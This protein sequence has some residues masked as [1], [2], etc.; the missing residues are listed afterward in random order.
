MLNTIY[1]K[2]LILFAF[3][4]AGSATWAQSP[5]QFTINMTGPST[6]TFLIEVIT[7][8]LTAQNNVFQFASTAPGTYQVMNIGRFVSN[9]KAFDK[10][11]KTI[12]V[13]QTNVNQFEI[14]QPE[15]VKK[16]T[17]SVAETFDTK[18]TEFPVYRMGGSSLE[19]DH[20]LLNAHTMLGY[21]VGMQDADIEIGLIHPTDW[22]VGTPLSKNK[23][24]FYTASSFDFAVDSPILL[25]RL[26]EASMDVEGKKIEIYT[27]SVTDMIKSTDLMTAMK[28]IFLAANTFVKG[29][30]VDRYVLLFHFED[31]SWGAWEHSYSSEYVLKE[32]P[33]TPET[34]QG[35]ASIAA[36]EIFHMVTP[37]NIHSEII[38]KFNFV[39]PT[40]SVHLWLYEGVTEWASDLMQLRAGLV[41]LEGTLEQIQQKLLTDDQF[42][43][44]YS[45]VKLAETSFEP[46]GNKQYGNIYNRG[47]LVPTL[48]DILLLEKSGGTR[49]L[50]EVVIELSKKYGPSK[51]F[52]E[53]DFF[54]EFVAITYPE[55]GPFLDNYIK[56]TEPLP[57]A[58]YF[59]KLGIEYLPET[60]NGEME[61]DRGHSINYNGKNLF[62]PE[63][64]ELSQS[65][66]L[67]SGDIILSIN[68]IEAAP[69]NFG[70]LI[71]L[72]QGAKK[73]DVYTYKIQR[74]EEVKEL[75]LSVGE[76][77]KV[78]KHSF[79]VLESATPEQLALRAAWSK[80][81]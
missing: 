55:V 41:T 4:A 2:T 52:S 26:T 81:L 50:R 39:T 47:A 66:G 54:N 34:A 45:L 71:P 61:A 53:K 77:E 51:A 42:D 8:K 1:R 11:G 23:K 30:P 56:N 48:L 33:L 74:G 73:G 38:E 15:K 37:L 68:E 5:V 29:F 70:T 7:P 14:S 31:Q 49:G 9:F 17:Y 69:A 59:A 60:K 64:R 6:D 16:I 79:K 65:E 25:G 24:G 44:S 46:E 63:A 80:N 58:E 57:V 76:R 35:I 62:V 27:Y 3:L 78:I 43:K 18:V 21:F 20:A 72:I 13:T 19:K 67:V 28:D 12:G 40:P 22:K 36:H 32:S 10:K 75:K